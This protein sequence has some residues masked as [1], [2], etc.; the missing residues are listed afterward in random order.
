[1]KGLIPAIPSIHAKLETSLSAHNQN[2]LKPSTIICKY[3]LLSTSPGNDLCPVN[4]ALRGTGQLG[5][6]H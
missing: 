6:M 5:S 2:S 3:G 1:M 4:L